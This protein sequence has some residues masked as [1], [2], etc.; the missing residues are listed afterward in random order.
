MND[1]KLL[2]TGDVASHCQVS[3]ETVSN[4][5]KSGKLKSHATPGRHRRIGREDFVDFL[6]HYDMPPLDA[7][8]SSPECRRLLLVDD[9][10]AILSLLT[11]YFQRD[12]M[13]YEVHTASDG[14][15]A[16]LQ[17]ARFHPDL[18]VLDLMMPYVDG[19]RVCKLIRSNPQMHNTGILVMTGY[20][21]Q[22]NAERA[23]K[24]GADRWLAK[25]F[26]PADLAQQ[27]EAI[28]AQRG[29]PV[30]RAGVEQR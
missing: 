20:A 5:I 2:T 18:V 30:L 28:L 7:L 23:L 10:P 3:Y 4:W 21:S 19:F 8:L 22:E 14:F 24:E 27:V 16:G 12:Q 26:D 9:E 13:P 11:R 15:E 25:P 17:M 1:R 29:K 6:S